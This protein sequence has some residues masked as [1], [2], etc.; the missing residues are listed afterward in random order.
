MALLIVPL[1]LTN[2]EPES[3]VLLKNLSSQIFPPDEADGEDAKFNTGL[4]GV[5]L[6]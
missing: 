4:L 6:R 3:K 2:A 1:T 5:S